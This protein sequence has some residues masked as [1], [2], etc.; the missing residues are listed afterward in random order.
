M[1]P[2]GTKCKSSGT[3]SKHYTD[4][5]L[6]P[7]SRSSLLGTASGGKMPLLDLF[8]AKRLGRRPKRAFKF[9]G[10]VESEQGEESAGLSAKESIRVPKMPP[11]PSMLHTAPPLVLGSLMGRQAEAF[12]H[13]LPEQSRSWKGQKQLQLVSK[14]S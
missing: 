11:T 9:W 4:G 12:R 13:C 7:A 14:A 5:I 8:A 6:S 2:L 10:S 3:H 1:W